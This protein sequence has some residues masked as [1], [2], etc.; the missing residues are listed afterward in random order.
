MGWLGSYNGKPALITK[1]GSAATGVVGGLSF[2]ELQANLHAWPYYA[3]KGL[4]TVLPSV[5]EM[6]VQFGFVIEAQGDAEMPEC[7]LGCV[8]MNYM[9]KTTFETIPP[10]LQTFNI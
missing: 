3:K 1:S 8:G 2:L 5:L 9:D 4:A 10:L 6:L 7:I